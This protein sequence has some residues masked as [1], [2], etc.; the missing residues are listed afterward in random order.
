I[1]N[2]TVTENSPFGVASMY[3]EV[4]GCT[5][6]HN[7]GVG[8]DCSW[9][10]RPTVRNCIIS[11]NSEGGVEC[12]DSGGYL[13]NCI[14]SGNRSSESG[15]GIRAVGE[16]NSLV[17]ENCVIVGNTTEGRG[18]AIICGTELGGGPLISSTIIAHNRNTAVAESG[19][20]GGS[21]G[22]P[23]IQNC[24]FYDNTGG[25]FYDYDTD[26]MAT[27]ASQINAFD[28]ASANI[29]GDP[30]F[31]SSGYWDPNGTIED[32][33]DD[34]WVDGGYHLKSQAGRWDPNSESW[35][36]DD[37]TSPCIDAGNPDSPIGHE[38]FPN[39]GI[40]NIGACGGSSQA[41]KSYFGGPVCETI[42][43]GDINGNCK[44]DYADFSLLALHW[45]EDNKP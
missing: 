24:L 26:T 7:K 29:D 22:D 32:A 27:G 44:I 1:I 17:I 13:F 10:I 5:I 23:R 12:F 3:G 33:N 4:I 19:G 45:L 2:C 30:C 43:A 37:V 31:A 28:L 25:D 16:I 39:G 18:G 14:I 21:N 40:I 8:L 6:S 11:H 36:Q 34:F 41:S 38:P 42:V 35:V 9:F 15:G 20:Y